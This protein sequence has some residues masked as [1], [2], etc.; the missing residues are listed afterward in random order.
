VR[1]TLA[2]IVFLFIA[3]S[4]VRFVA[5]EYRDSGAK[6]AVVVVPDSEVYAKNNKKSEHITEVLMGDEFSVIREAGDW[7]YGS[8]PS[9]K[10]Y[11]GWIRKQ[12]ISFSLSESPFKGR[13]FVLVRS[14]KTRIS[15]RDGSST[16]VF[17]GTRLPLLKDNGN[18]YEVITPDGST[19]FL[20]A[21]SVALEDENFGKNVTPQDIL[22]ASHFF[23]SHYKWGGI[24]AGGMDCSGFVYTVF[25][26]NGIYLKR[27]S[28]MQAEEGMEISPDDLREGDLVFFS[29]KKG[30]RIT[31]VGIYIGDG[32]FIHSSRGKKGV[33]VSSLSEANFRKRLAAARRILP[34]SATVQGRGNAERP[35]MNG[36][37]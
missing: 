32:K 17:A 35:A 37:A 14:T 30:G 22:T 2:L 10:G 5:G 21:G 9:Q 20:P 15:Y 6:N 27:D 34:A 1:R 8:I 16:D 18:R 11:T 31:H 19:G 23:T 33:A 29:S 36:H 28:Y 13:S 25:R 4:P 7:V 24:T 26:I 3:A 12:D